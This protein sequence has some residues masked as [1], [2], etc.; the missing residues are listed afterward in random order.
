[1]SDRQ[2]YDET[3]PRRHTIKLRSML[4]EIV[5]HAREDVS[6]INEPKAQ[7]IFET[8][9]EACSGLIKALEDYETQSEE[10]MRH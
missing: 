3:D 2:Q 5:Q 9:A 4:E 1:M 7:A 10:A 8:T 6:K